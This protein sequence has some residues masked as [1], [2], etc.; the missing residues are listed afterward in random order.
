MYDIAH[1]NEKL[2]YKEFGVNAKFLINHAWG[3]ETCTIEQIKK[4]KPKSQSISNSQ[5][6]FRD[7]N[8]EDAKKVFIEMIDNLLCNLVD[9]KLYTDPV[10]GEQVSKKELKKRKLLKRVLNHPRQQIVQIN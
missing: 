10:T 7:Y 8:F 4:Y 1:C 2:L 5:I 9:K 6:L 3:K